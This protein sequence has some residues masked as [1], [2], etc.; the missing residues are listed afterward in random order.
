MLKPDS[1][2][3]VKVGRT[4]R[5]QLTAKMGKAAKKAENSQRSAKRI[6]DRKWEKA[7]KN[8]MAK[9]L[10]SGISKRDDRKE[11]PDP[12]SRQR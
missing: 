3:Q 4:E 12:G 10:S 11:N 8:T 1:G 9:W 2:S 5:H 7:G 6:E